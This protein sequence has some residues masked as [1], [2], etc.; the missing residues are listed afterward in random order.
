MIALIFAN[1]SMEHPTRLPEYDV[2]IAADGGAYHCRR[3]GLQPDWVIGDL[4]STD[5]A[6]LEG[7]QAG[8]T[9]VK[10]FP[11]HKDY[12]D[13]ELAVLHA[14]GLG[15]TQV[16][17]LAALGARWDQTLA[18][19]LLPA[20]RQFASLPVKLLD[21]AQ[22]ITLI[23]PGETRAICGRPGDTLSL[24]PLS[25]DAQGITTSGL[26]YPL[27][28]EDLL[29]GSTR[30][31]SNVLLGTCAEIKLNSGMLICTLI[32]HDGEST[33]EN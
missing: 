32:H 21:G 2:L 17:I 25:G 15:A 22:E 3:L 27:Q 31:V 11:T 23:R 30:G 6:F 12:T 10:H 14:Q 9:R 4:D 1:G 24:I 29:F 26:E 28:D 13:L 20:A 7:L 16:V 33:D 8:G 18:N 19:L 5:P